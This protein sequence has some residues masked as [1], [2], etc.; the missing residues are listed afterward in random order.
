MDL[1]SEAFE[2]LELGKVDWR[3]YLHDQGETGRV[4]SPAD[5]REEAY[6][7]LENI[8]TG[9]GA[10]MPWEK[11]HLQFQFRP[12]EFSIWAG[13]GGSGK[14]L[15]TTQ[16]ALQLANQG[17]KGCI[18]SPE[19]TA[20]AQV[21]RLVRQ[22]AGLASPTQQVF[23]QALE[24]MDEN[25]YLYV[26]ESTP[27]EDE[28]VGIMRFCRQ[29]LGVGFFVIDS[30][31][32]AVAGT[33]D[34]NRQKNFCDR[35]AREARDTGMHIALVAHTRKSQKDT[36]QVDRMDIA[37]TSSISD[38]ADVVGVLNRNRQQEREL[39]NVSHYGAEETLG[40][41]FNET[42]RPDPD[43]FLRIAKQRH[44]SGWEGS[45]GLWF[46]R[47]SQCFTETQEPWGGFV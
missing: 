2:I 42:V 40:V 24:W 8:N 4:K 10:K 11:T 9:L 38:L 14:S 39:E 45:F 25:I 43:A 18:W 33:D 6:Q 36:D 13:S 5:F 35:M 22:C 27:S 16:Y 44:G 31:M 46:D 15:L 26:R 29:E 34:Y 47:A 32:K 7:V 28:L 30:L 21:A 19:M 20:P 37:G 12:S 41:K 3:K 23:R 17:M 1:M